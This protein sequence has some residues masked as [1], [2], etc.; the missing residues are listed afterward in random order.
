MVNLVLNI[1]DYDAGKCDVVHGTWGYCIEYVCTRCEVD[2]YGIWRDAQDCSRHD[3][4]ALATGVR[5]APSLSCSCT[6]G[7]LVQLSL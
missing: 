5:S 6:H 4:R 7:N 1:T 2:R 3:Q